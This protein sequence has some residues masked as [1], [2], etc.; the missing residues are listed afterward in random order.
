MRSSLAIAVFLC[1]LAPAQTTRN[2]PAQY[3]TIQAAINVC[4]NSDDVLVA[5]GVHPGAINFLGKAITV[6]SSGGAAVTTIHGT[7]SA[8][9]ATLATNESSS[10]VLDGFTITGGNGGLFLQNTSCVIQNCVITNNFATNNAGGG[11]RCLSTGSSVASPTINNC[12][13]VG[14][15]EVPSFAYLGTNEDVELDCWVNGTGDP[16]ASTRAGPPG[17]QL[18]FLFQSPG[19]TLV[20]AEPLVAGV[21][22][23]TGS[24]PSPIPGF[25]QIWL[26]GIV[27]VVAGSF[28]APPFSVPGL[29]SA[30]ITLEYLVPSGLGGNT[31][32][33]QALVS[34]SFTNNGMWALTNATEVVL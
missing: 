33:L 14:A 9:T 17:S 3:P 12:S 30:G 16:L 10:A 26:N 32:R 5:P 27:F 20:G 11:I 22:F 13:I 24:P 4:V 25:P 29:P 31:V 18:K 7:P 19:G 6:H 28:G 8:A 21:L 2:V 15:D 23:S 1:S 34:S